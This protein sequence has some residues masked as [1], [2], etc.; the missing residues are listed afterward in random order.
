[1]RWALA[2]VAS[3]LLSVQ[4]APPLE[5]DVRVADVSPGGFSVLWSVDA[6][7]T[8]GLELYRDVLGSVPVTDATITASDGEVLRVR[9]AGLD[10]GTPYF[11]RTLT[12]AASDPLP[13]SGAL[14]S[15]VTAIDSDATTRR[16]LAATVI[17]DDGTTELPGAA[18][19][20]ELPGA[21]SPLSAIAGQ[22]YAGARATVTLSNLYG[23]DGLPFDPAGG[24]MLTLT[25]LASGG[26][27]ASAS[28]PLD[29]NDGSGA[30]QLAGTL[31]LQPLIDADLDGLPDDYEAAN[32]ITEPLADADLD[33]LLNIDEYRRGSD[34][35]VAD[36][37]GDG[38]SDGDEDALHGTFPTL[39]DTDRDG[40]SDGEEV[41]GVPAT[42]P[43]D[44]DSDDDGVSDG[45]EIAA[46]SDPNDAQD[47]PVL[48]VDLDGVG[49]L[50]DNCPSIPNPGQEDADLDGSGDVCDG[51]DDGDT[52]ADALDNCPRVANLDQADADLDGVG[53]LCDNC[54]ALPNADQLDNEGDGLGDA[55]DPDDDDDGIDDLG[56]LPP[57]SDVP[58]ELLDISG[59]VSTSLPFTTDVQAFVSVGKF[60]QAD[61]RLVR[62]GFL[63]L[64][65]R[66]FTAET[67]DPADQAM[68]GWLYIGLDLNSCDC[69]TVRERDTLTVATDAGNITAVMP[70]DAQD[71]GV[72]LL[73][74]VDGS[75]WSAFSLTQPRLS[76]LQQNANLAPALDN[77]IFTPN[78]AQLDSDGDGIGDLCDMTPD[79]VDGDSVLNGVDNCP[80][81]NNPDQADLDG[82]GA[83]DRCDDDDDADGLSDL[84]E[85]TLLR[86]DTL[87]ADTDGDGIADGDED[88]DLDGLGNLAELAA[89]RSPLDP[90]VQLRAGPNF[91]AY[92]VEVPAGL[93]AFALLA[94]L[95][96]E[97]EVVAIHRLDTAAQV[98]ESASYSGATPTGVDF[99]IVDGEGYLVEM[100]VDRLQ[101][102]SG[103][104]DCASIDIEIGYNLV[105]FPCVPASFDQRELLFY[106]SGGAPA[107]ASLQGLDAESGRF[108]TAGWRSGSF[109]TG[110]RGSLAAG[111]AYVLFSQA[112]RLATP[113]P[114]AA[115]TI[116][117][118]A[119][120]DGGTTATT[121]TAV[122]GTVSPPDAIVT[123]GATLAAVDGSGNFSAEIDLAEGANVLTAQARTTDN[124]TETTSLTITLDTSVAMDHV[125]ARPD[126]QSGSRMFNV[127]AGSLTGIDHIDFE[128]VG[129]PAGVSYLAGSAV[130]DVAGGDVTA[131]YDITSDATA[132]VGIHAFQVTYV[133]RDAGNAE[134][135]RHTLDFTIEVLP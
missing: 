34:P 81:D 113:A 61:Q 71:L 27:R 22:G 43:L 51:D 83:G 64:R 65:T 73:V 94:N 15:A 110:E 12:G 33:G 107:I 100:Q 60:F 103:K 32:A 66:E 58:F 117:L 35:N 9:V 99:P 131:P 116:A 14:L 96:G 68:P 42:D 129:V 48:D 54:D 49:D 134:L 120:F 93:T 77:C 41:N 118:T 2:I 70:P 6:P 40:R 89:G 123:I 25:A 39:A 63:D 8:A 114:L 102:F 135:A 26:R 57:A 53:D 7:S 125:L 21:L 124:L 95:G 10:P 87:A 74:S 104:P 69:F 55:C 86:T 59:I 23:T 121:P 29:A 108:A 28:P 76:N 50:V 52:L 105:G 85:A 30:T 67:V 91:F 1:M 112:Q 18:L 115:P 82:D 90:E 98:F 78:F 79:D 88:F 119:P 75:T 80:N 46:G 3:L 47:F 128:F 44:A 16:A 133:F 72:V 38:L 20:V 84:D 111:R 126:S 24:T 106:L 92:P 130:V 11:F 19:L 62:Y 132:T 109:T 45:A 17:D 56:P 4:A 101:S 122:T 5:R 13:A 37:D 31:V 36:S 127:G 97:S